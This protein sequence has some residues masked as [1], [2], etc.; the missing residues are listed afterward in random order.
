MSWG[1]TLLIE[2]LGRQMTHRSSFSAFK[3]C[4]AYLAVTAFSFYLAW[5]IHDLRAPAQQGISHPKARP[6]S[7]LWHKTPTWASLLP[8]SSLERAK[9]SR[10]AAAAILMAECV[11]LSIFH[12][13]SAQY[14]FQIV[15][16]LIFCVH[17][18]MQ[19]SGNGI[20]ISKHLRETK[21][22]SNW[23][24]VTFIYTTKDQPPYI[25]HNIHC[26]YILCPWYSWGIKCFWGQV[27]EM[28]SVWTV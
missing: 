11:H 4:A 20:K 14:L 10:A 18:N 22:L 1:Q 6:S 24:S 19:F 7:K 26:R 15:E 5:V 25:K 8:A 13:L 28:K 17:K 2:S 16:S 21:N 27:W 9:G 23:S 12:V 3:N